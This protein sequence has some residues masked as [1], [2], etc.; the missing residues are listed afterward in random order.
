MDCST[1]SIAGVSSPATV[2]DGQSG[3]TATCGLTG[4]VGNITIGCSL[5]NI[6]QSGNCG[7]DTANGYS[8][9]GGVCVKQCSVSV[10]G[11]NATTVSSGVT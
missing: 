1:S 9:S 10:N 6:S 2:T 4:Y 5:G 11:S 8:L 3:V 7:C